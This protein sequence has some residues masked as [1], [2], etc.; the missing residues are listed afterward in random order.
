MQV[1]KSSSSHKSTL[2][3][4][5]AGL[6]LFFAAL[7]YFPSFH[8]PFLVDDDALITHHAQ[9]YRH[10]FFTTFKQ[11]YPVVGHLVDRPLTLLTLWVNYQWHGLHPVGYKAANILFHGLSCAASFLF[12]Q[13]LLMS[14]KLEHRK[15]SWI[16]ALLMLCHPVHTSTVNIV[17]QRG[18]L[19]ANLFGFLSLYFFLRFRFEEQKKYWI[20]FFTT[21]LLCLL[22]KPN[23]IAFALTVPLY[24][25]IFS[26]STQER[27]K[28]LLAS[29]PTFL[30]FAIPLW[31]YIDRVSVQEVALNSWEYFLVQTRVIFTFFKLF[32]I[33]Y[34]LRFQ[35]D[36]SL[37]PDLSKNFTWMALTAHLILMSLGILLA[38]SKSP[39]S[40]S[41]HTSYRKLLG[42]GILSTYLALAPQSSFIPMV[43]PIF[44]YRVYSV[45]FF[46]AMTVVLWLQYLELE[47]KNVPLLTLG[48]LIF[49]GFST[50]TFYRNQ[51][52]DST[53]KWHYEMVKT[54]KQD[55]RMNLITI[56]LLI[57]NR[58]LKKAVELADAL[59]EQKSGQ[60]LHYHFIQDLLKNE[61]STLESKIKLI[62]TYHQQLAKRYPSYFP[63]VL[64]TME[65]LLRLIPP[66]DQK[67]IL[68]HRFLFPYTNYILHK[69]KMLTPLVIV[70]TDVLNRLKHAYAQE[71]EEKQ[72][73][74][75]ALTILNAPKGIS[76]GD[77]Y[78]KIYSEHPEWEKFFS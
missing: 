11:L 69:R 54:Y 76:Y 44:E 10:D 9:A 51:S 13:Y 63:F 33:P 67:D 46:L 74:E 21:L 62:D 17:I 16:I 22:S 31:G 19:L 32:F 45:Y 2:F 59:A 36:I 4:W 61:S 3:W 55:E 53:A 43:F 15:T 56:D 8:S 58:E 35:Y 70:Y 39:P 50:L 28:L 48:L 37:D 6:F 23:G 64:T 78:R 5:I 40:S 30:L 29:V 7:L 47:K 57:R 18:M 73:I 26:N 12:F 34:P 1:V 38:C 71:N 42:F 72:K 66:V 60:A 75:A 27:K 77:F 25:L 24:V 49:A 41:H 14:L 52:I 20:A 68:R 65:T